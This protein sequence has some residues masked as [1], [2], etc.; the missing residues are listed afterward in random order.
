MRPCGVTVRCWRSIRFLE[1]TGALVCDFIDLI[2]ADQR[3][4]YEMET[5][6]MNTSTKIFAFLAAFWATWGVLDARADDYNQNMDRIISNMEDLSRKDADNTQ[7]LYNPPASA[8]YPPV[9][10]TLQ[11]WQF[12]NRPVR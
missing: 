8:Y 1:L 11:N 5:V 6:I 3:L 10:S 4:V 2:D 9:E 12:N 7:Q